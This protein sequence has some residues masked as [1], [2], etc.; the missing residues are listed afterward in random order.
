MKRSDGPSLTSDPS[1]SE[2]SSAKLRSASNSVQ[3]NMG[4]ITG[5]A[6]TLRVGSGNYGRSTRPMCAHKSWDD[7]SSGRSPDDTPSASMMNVGFDNPKP[8]RSIS[9][10]RESFESLHERDERL[11][12]LNE[13]R[14]KEGD[15]CIYQSYTCFPC[16]YMYACVQLVLTLSQDE[17][18][19]VITEVWFQLIRPGSGIAPQSHRY[20]YMSVCVCRNIE[21]V[22]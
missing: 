1:S 16:M 22:V 20:R 17:V 9:G 12:A 19:Y 6:D 2:L 15:L 10:R 3:K 21:W 7:A 14:E 4:E 8:M 11:M 13:V 18:E 5:G